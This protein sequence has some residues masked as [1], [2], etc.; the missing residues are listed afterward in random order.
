MKVSVPSFTSVSAQAKHENRSSYSVYQALCW[1]QSTI[2]NVM[3]RIV[4]RWEWVHRCEE[5]V[6]PVFR[7][8][9]TWCVHY[10]FSKAWPSMTR[11]WRAYLGSPDP[12]PA[13]TLKAY[14][15][16]LSRVTVMICRVDSWS[17]RGF[18]Y[19]FMATLGG[20]HSLLNKYWVFHVSWTT[21]RM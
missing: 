19:M 18:Q 21:V 2:F 10:W 5:W 6:C 16:G 13:G 7:Q 3:G 9:F 12:Q 17:R 20:F 8:T 15:L 14:S 4:S 1:F 11:Q